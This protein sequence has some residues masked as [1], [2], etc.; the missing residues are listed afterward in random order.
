MPRLPSSFLG[1]TKAKELINTL[2]TERNLFYIR[3]QSVPRG[4]HSLPWL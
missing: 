1:N 4:K 2:K 3:T